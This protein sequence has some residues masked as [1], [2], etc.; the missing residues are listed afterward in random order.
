MTPIEA[1]MAMTQAGDKW[2]SSNKLTMCA[3]SAELT[4]KVINMKPASNQKGARLK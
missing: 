4:L 1:G 2:A 3:G